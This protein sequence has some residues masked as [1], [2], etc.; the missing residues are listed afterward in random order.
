M[1]QNGVGPGPAA[2]ATVPIWL[3]GPQAPCE[4]CGSPHWVTWETA[5]SRPGGMFVVMPLNIWSL[6]VLENVTERGL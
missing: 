6:S 1:I 2:D 5:A 4:A 3:S